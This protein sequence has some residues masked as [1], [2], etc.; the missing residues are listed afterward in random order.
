MLFKNKKGI[1]A[2]PGLLGGLLGL[3]FGAA[4]LGTILLLLIAGIPV[5]IASSKLFGGG[6]TLFWI[7]LSAFV[8][9]FIV[10]RR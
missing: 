10:R 1:A 6:S 7:A 5:I 4:A 9:I 2:G 3:G 8:L